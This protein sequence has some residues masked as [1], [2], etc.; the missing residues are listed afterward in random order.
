MLCCVMTNPPLIIP[1]LN[2]LPENLL[3]DGSVRLEVEQGIVIF[4]A[5]ARV[6]ER[7][8]ELLERRSAGTLSAEE[9]GEL[10]AYEEVDDYLSHVN[11]L[12]RNLSQASEVNLAA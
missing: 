11:R 5:S 10:L 6:Q 12:I 4:R 7:I 3:S 2:R 1:K 9:E 8:G